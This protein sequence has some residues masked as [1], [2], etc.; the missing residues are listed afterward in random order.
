MKL[1]KDTGFCCIYEYVECRYGD[2]NSVLRATDEELQQIESIKSEVDL[3]T[4][5]SGDSNCDKCP[6]LAKY[7][8]LNIL[9]ALKKSYKVIKI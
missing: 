5:W 4:V 7:D 2:M 1:E 3:A 6:M 9:N 8:S